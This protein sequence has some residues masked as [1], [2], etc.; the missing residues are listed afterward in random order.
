MTYS[1][2]NDL[3]QDPPVLVLQ[4]FHSC[5]D[6]RKALFHLDEIARNQRQSYIESKSSKTQTF[7]LSS[8]N[9]PL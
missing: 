5:N 6:A 7:P 8:K 3:S 2:T 1:D 4:G 9:D